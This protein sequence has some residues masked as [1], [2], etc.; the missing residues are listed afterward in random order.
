MI[1]EELKELFRELEV[2]G[3]NPQLCDTPVPVYETPVHCGDPSELGN[4]VREGDEEWMPRKWTSLGETFLTTVFGDSM[5]DADILEGDLVKV[6]R[7]SSYNDGD[8]LLVS[9]DGEY[10]LKAYCRDENGTPW[11]VPQNKAYNSIQFHDNQEVIV[12]GVVREVVKRTPR[13]SYRSCIS[14]INKTKAKMAERR[15]ITPDVVTAALQQIALDIKLARQWYAVFRVLVDE[16]VM[17][18]K[19]YES[20][21]DMVRE[22]VPDHAT[23]PTSDGLQRIAVDSF[24][25][26]VARWT[27]TDAPVQGKRYEDYLRIAHRMQELLAGE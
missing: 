17:K 1:D 7:V 16:G 8:I 18:A 19:D 15:E 10:A 6:E 13:I 20:F 27:P 9:V 11:L 12:R 24:A 21:C 26:P 23:L 22:A 14:A 3:W 2:Q 5:K 25:K 4:M